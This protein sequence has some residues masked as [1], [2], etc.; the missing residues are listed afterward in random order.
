MREIILPRGRGRE[1][2]GRRYA[3]IVQADDLMALSTVAVCPTSRSAPAASFHPEVQVKGEGTKV[4]CEMVRAVDAR[5]LGSH[6]G[7]LGLK[8]IGAVDDALGLVLELG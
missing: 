6:I 2:H 8:E 1:Q 5:R 4:L 3:V 7:H